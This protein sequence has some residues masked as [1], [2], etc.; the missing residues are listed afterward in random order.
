MY[1]M[2]WYVSVLSTLH[3]ISRHH[4]ALTLSKSDL[5]KVDCCAPFP[6][7]DLAAPWEPR[8][9]NLLRDSRSNKSFKADIQ[10]N[11]SMITLENQRIL[12]FSHFRTMRELLDLWLKFERNTL[13]IAQYSCHSI[14]TQIGLK[15]ETPVGRGNKLAE[16]QTEN[17]LPLDR[18][19]LDCFPNL[20]SVSTC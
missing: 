17:F 13:Y 7:I 1:H 8:C 5:I 2:I 18:S 20:F 9:T 12:R 6:V 4:L 3:S 14:R 15:V 10:H 11:L 19:V 16:S